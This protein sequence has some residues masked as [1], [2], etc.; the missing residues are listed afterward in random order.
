MNKEKTITIIG[1]ILIAIPFFTNWMSVEWEF[2]F[3]IT[4]AILFGFFKIDSRI[5][6]LPAILTLAFIPFLL[7]IK[8]QALAETL[9]IYVY[10]LLVV[11]VILQIVEYKRKSKNKLDLEILLKK[12]HIDILHLFG[13]AAIV[14]FGILYLFNK[15]FQKQFIIIFG[16]YALTILLYGVFYLLKQD[17]LQNPKTQRQE[18]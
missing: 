13:L 6:I 18:Q 3:F 16:V 11:G 2:L 15:N 5:L 10:Y 1:I 7:I 8:N 17:K 12:E 4:A 14:G 9:A